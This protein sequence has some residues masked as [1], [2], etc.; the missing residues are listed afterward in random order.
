MDSK[1]RA[2]LIA[3]FYQA[4]N[5]RLLAELLMDLEED[6]RVRAHVRQALE[7]L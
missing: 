5:T 6:D 3:E 4:P 7:K 2:R 1:A